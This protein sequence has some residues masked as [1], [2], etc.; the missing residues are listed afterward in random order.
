MG[1]NRKSSFVDFFNTIAEHKRVGAW[2]AFLALAASG[3]FLSVA[4]ALFHSC[5]IAFLFSIMVILL[6]IHKKVATPPSDLR[7]ESLAECWGD[8]K[9][10]LDIAF[11]GENLE[12]SWVG[13]TLHEA[14]NH[15]SRELRPRLAQ[16][17]CPKMEL[18][19]SQCHP[20]ALKQWVGNSSPILLKARAYWEDITAFCANHNEAFQRTE[21]TLRVDR[22]HYMPNFHG[23]LINDSILYLS[24][25]RW[26][27]STLLIADEPYERHTDATER[28]RYSI[29]LYRSWVSAASHSAETERES[30]LIRPSP[31]THSLELDKPARD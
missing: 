25:V 17:S 24:T 16:R 27:G 21:S 4:P 14:W 5:L 30:C 8:I 6:D 20:D 26:E 15:I 9:H 1:V 23:V 22:Y 11:S 10:D 2:V 18:R 28:G 12:I 31:E 3:F 7:Y 29:D 13:V 19:F